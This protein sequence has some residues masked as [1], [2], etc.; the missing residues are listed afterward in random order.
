MKDMVMYLVKLD[1]NA[2]TVPSLEK[3]ILAAI[4]F[5]HFNSCDANIKERYTNFTNLINFISEKPIIADFGGH[6]IHIERIV[7]YNNPYKAVETTLPF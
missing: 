6:S 1:E 7:M 3:A 5:I 2:F 4:D